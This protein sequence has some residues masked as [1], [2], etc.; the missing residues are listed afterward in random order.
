MTAL[1]ASQPQRRREAL[2]QQ[3]LNARSMGDPLEIARAEQQWVHRYG[4]AS[5]PQADS[6]GPVTLASS[7]DGTP[8]AHQ[9]LPISLQQETPITVQEKAPLVSAFVRF[10]TA[11]KGCLED[12][13]TVV[14][15]PTQP[16]DQLPELFREVPPPPSPRLQRLRRWLPASAEDLPKAS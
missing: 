13:G 1:S 10:K 16:L 5:L 6:D 7:L 8:V 9:P 3:L 11:L 12:V 4:V 2:F 14:E 15:P